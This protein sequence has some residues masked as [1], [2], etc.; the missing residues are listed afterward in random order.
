MTKVKKKYRWRIV[1]KSKDME[2]IIRE[3]TSILDDFYA[4]R[5]ERNIEMSVDINPV[6]MF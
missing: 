4:T 5:K 6:N 1:I 2:R 3:L